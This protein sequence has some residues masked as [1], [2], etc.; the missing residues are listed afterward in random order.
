MYYDVY[1]EHF[2]KR[3]A[4]AF[5]K[6]LYYAGFVFS[7]LLGI[8]AA[9]ISIGTFAVPFILFVIVT[10]YEYI[11]IYT[12]FDY[13]YTNGV[14]EIDKVTGKKRRKA[15]ISVDMKDVV[16]I[17]R[18]KSDPVSQYVG[19]YM[20]TYDCT[21]HEDVPYYCMIVR[22]NGIEEKVLFEPTEEMLQEMKRMNS[23][24]V[25]IG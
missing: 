22:R 4:N 23:S 6:I 5:N 25:H 9:L 21:S 18:S 3:K 16:V 15:L 20:K 1:C 17:A 12:E 11:Q 19:R 2:V 10:Y 13:G 14:F 7:V 8:L 24:I